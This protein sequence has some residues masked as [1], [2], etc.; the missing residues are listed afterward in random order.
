MQV[1]P[2]VLASVILNIVLFIISAVLASKGI[3]L[4]NVLETTERKLRLV[5]DLLDRIEESYA[6]KV[7]TPSEAQSIIKAFRRVLEDP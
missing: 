1:D 5:T 6:D 2:Y 3:S 4:R 7:I